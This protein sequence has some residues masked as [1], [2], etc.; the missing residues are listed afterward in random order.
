[1]GNNQRRR[2][3]L[4]LGATAGGLLAA[5]F[6]PT[7]VAFADEYDFVPD[8]TT[9]DT[10]Q[11]EGY[12]PLVNEVTGTDNYH[13]TSTALIAPNNFLMEGATQVDLANFGD[14]RENEWID[15]PS[16][17]D[18]GISDLLITLCGD[19]QLPGSFFSDLATAL[20]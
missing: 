10:T 13:L 11:V 7:A 17:S 1:M 15:V 12:P 14:G 6:L 19:F 3:V 9:L 18:P 8:T 2:V 16:G 20:G 4:T 5:A